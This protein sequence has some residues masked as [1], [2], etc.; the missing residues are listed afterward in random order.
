MDSLVISIDSIIFEVEI[1]AAELVNN[2][3]L[4][5]K[6]KIISW[7]KRRSVRAYLALHG[8][9]AGHDEGVEGN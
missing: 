8:E 6:M 3:I 4:R 5:S 7:A 9:V 1:T 2:L